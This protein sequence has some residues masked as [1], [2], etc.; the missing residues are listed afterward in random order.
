MAS[1]KKAAA[2]SKVAPVAKAKGAAP[3]SARATKKKA[4]KPGRADSTPHQAH[5]SLLARVA[6]ALGTSEAEAEKRALRELAARLGLDDA[7]ASKVRAAPPALHPTEVQQKGTGALPK[8][9]FLA[10]DGR[11]LDGMGLPV[12]VIDLPCQIG[13]S[14]TC[15]VWVNSPQIETRH[16]QVTH[17]DA[18]WV[19]EDLGSQHGTWFEG[20]KIGRRVL[21]HGDVFLLAGYLRLR[22]E[23]RG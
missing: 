20:Q 9:L 11:G 1:V 21:Q 4:G 7:P 16:A 17:G 12:E 18:G 14:K 15:A 6:R 19:L 10:L 3:K 5:G 13:S 8:R 23:L 2:R 22:A